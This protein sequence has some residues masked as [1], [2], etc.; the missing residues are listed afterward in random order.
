MYGKIC[1]KNVREKRPCKYAGKC[2]QKMP[3]KNM[4][5]KCAGSMRKKKCSK[6][7]NK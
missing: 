3:V 6:K 2:L 5:E 1:A 4:R 7:W